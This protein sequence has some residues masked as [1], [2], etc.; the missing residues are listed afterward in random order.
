MMVLVKVDLGIRHRG[1]RHYFVRTRLSFAIL[2][3][4]SLCLRGSRVQWQCGLGFDDGAA[5]PAH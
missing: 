1:E 4:A 5:L 3:S 2:R